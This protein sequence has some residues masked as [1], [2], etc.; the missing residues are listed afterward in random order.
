M[1][2]TGPDLA[3]EVALWRRGIR[4]VAGADEVGRGPLAGP[5]V[6]AA[7]VLPAHVPA[8]ALAGVDDSKRLSPAQRRRLAA[9]IRR[10]AEAWAVVEVG[11]EEVDRL[12]IAA[13]SQEAVRRAVAALPVP[14]GHVLVDGYANPRLAWPQ[15]ALVG[16]DGRTLSVAAASVLA[17]VHRDALMEAL[18]ARYPGYGFAEHKGYPTPAHR[19]ALARLGPSPVHRRSFRLLGGA[20]A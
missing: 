14:I 11:V 10:V 4:Y 20:S 8:E 17:K 13:A 18:D 19:E 6:A 15:T 1:G 9:R 2:R 16:G 12:R 7:V 3:H 5:V